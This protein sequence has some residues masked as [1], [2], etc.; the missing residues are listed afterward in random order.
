MTDSLRTGIGATEEHAL[1]LMDS[2]LR[3]T[4]RELVN[5][6]SVDDMTSSADVLFRAPRFILSH[7]T[8]ADP[9]LNYGNALA[10][11]LWE[12]DWDKLT[13]TPSRLTAEPMERAER[14]RFFTLVT[15][16]GYVD[17][18]TSIRISST[19]RR[20]YIKQATVWNVIDEAGVY[21]GQAATF[22]EYSY[23]E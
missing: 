7:G 11:K 17:D 10:L 8:Q 4:G 9:V 21:R 23:I 1:L 15:A 3:W 18:Y 6:E 16:N 5:R 20:F 13:S 12:M 19:G 2:Y 22:T 14:D